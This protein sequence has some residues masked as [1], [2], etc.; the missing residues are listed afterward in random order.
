LQTGAFHQFAENATPVLQEPGD[1]AGIT[2]AAFGV[3]SMEDARSRCGARLD[4]PAAA[5]RTPHFSVLLFGQ[6]V[7][8]DLIANRR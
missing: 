6:S 2:C 4:G 1:S 8:A 7:W 3:G 5:I